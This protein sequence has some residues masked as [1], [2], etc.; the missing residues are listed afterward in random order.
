VSHSPNGSTVNGKPVATGKAHPLK[1]G[2]TIGVGKQKLLTV[3]FQPPV[4]KGAAEEAAAAPARQS[5]MS[6]RAK[7]WLGIGIYM[8]IALVVIIVLWGLKKEE[9]APQLAAAQVSDQEIEA[10]IR[11]PLVRAPDER[12]A[13]RTLAEAQQ[14]YPRSGGHEAGLFH[15]H[16]NYKLALA[17]SGKT[18]FEGIDQLQFNEVENALVQTITRDYRAAYARVRSLEWSAAETLLRGI[19]QQYPDSQSIIWK[20]VSDQLRIVTA[21]RVRK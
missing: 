2:D 6:R 4:A 21:R 17:F 11:R 3:Q 7:L 13:A 1:P 12:E 15:T 5:D 19:L 10:E 8:V 14:W 9:A 20:N 16:R 18:S